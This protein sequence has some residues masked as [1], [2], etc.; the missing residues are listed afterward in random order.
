MNCFE[1]TKCCAIVVII[2]TILTFEGIIINVYASDTTVV[3]IDLSSQMINAG[4]MF[5]VNVSCVPNQ[6]IRSFE[7]KLSFNPL[8]L[9]ANSVTE[10][11]IFNGYTT[12]FNSGTI[13]NVAGTIANIFDLI[14]GSGNISNAGTFIIISFTAQS[15]SGTSNLH[16]YD[17]G[18]TTE[19][20]Y[21][22][23]TVNDASVIV[24][25]TE[26]PPDTP[27]SGGPSNEPPVDLA[28]QNNP[29]N[30]PVKPS[31]PMFIERG[32]IYAYTSSAFDSDG[33]HV[34]L[35]FDWGDG[36]LSDW[37]LFVDANTTISSS[38]TW[39]NTSSYSIYVIAQDERGLNSSWSIPLNITV[40]ELNTS[41][42]PPLVDI[43][44]PDNGY[45]NQTILFNASSSIDPDR[46]IISYTW[47]FG[48]GATETGKTPT[49]SYNKSGIYTVILTVTD[50]TGKTYSKTFIVTIYADSESS[51][52]NQEFSF[53]FLS[54]ALVVVMCL[55]GI[56]L[57]VLFRKKIQ[58][59]FSSRSA[60]YQSK[61]IERLNVK[62]T[63]LNQNIS[64]KPKPSDEKYII[65]DQKRSRSYDNSIEEQ[66]DR[67]IISKIEEKI[68]EM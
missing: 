62:I 3:R 45:V 65:G 9:H 5:I 42:E 7:L 19:T 11:N 4:D 57:I 18:V 56:S 50:N 24:Q 54:V 20:E 46:V 60:D 14:V 55:I 52:N 64:K 49:H 16:L 33:D 23:I 29:P 53:P 63:E 34:R 35:R 8:L 51:S 30:T 17:V 21:I 37:S 67:I 13:D 31:G 15:Y 1:K 26:N 6:P 41:E 10:G 12:F 27:P 32:V 36:S 25:G 44:A 61:R 68:D 58:T 66:V 43:K 59:I 38:H 28:S 22:P 40:S 2:G 48:D 39:S 47:D